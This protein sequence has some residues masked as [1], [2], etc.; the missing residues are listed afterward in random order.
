[1]KGE[2]VGEGNRQQL[3]EAI[4]QAPSN[5]SPRGSFDAWLV[6]MKAVNE[7]A[8]QLRKEN[9]AAAGVSRA[10]LDTPEAPARPKAPTS[11]APAPN[12][13]PPPAAAPSSATDRDEAIRMLRLKPNSKYRTRLMQMHNI[14]DAELAQ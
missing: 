9:L 4:P 10:D 13:P 5:L 1:M 11:V 6:K 7:E 2:S 3:E 14:T 8:R 12:A